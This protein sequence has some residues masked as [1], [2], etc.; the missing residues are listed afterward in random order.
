MDTLAYPSH[1]MDYRVAYDVRSSL[2]NLTT[3]SVSNSA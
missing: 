3:V 2:A 1:L